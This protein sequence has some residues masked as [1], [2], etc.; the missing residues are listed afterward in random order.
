MKKLLVAIILGVAG[1]AMAELTAGE[2]SELQKLY[3]ANEG[4]TGKLWEIQNSGVQTFPFTGAKF[5]LN[6]A[7]FHLLS[8]ASGQIPE[9]DGLP[10][11]NPRE[12]DIQLAFGFIDEAIAGLSQNALFAEEVAILQ[13]FNRSLPYADAVSGIFALQDN[14]LPGGDPE[15]DQTQFGPHGHYSRALRQLWLVSLYINSSYYSSRDFALS[16]ELVDYRV[17]LGL[18]ADCVARIMGLSAH[19]ALLP[20]DSP[21]VNDPIRRPL[22]ELSI[23][24]F[25]VAVNFRK[26]T[27]SLATASLNLSKTGKAGPSIQTL[28]APIDHLAL[29]WR[30]L[31]HWIWLF[32]NISEVPVGG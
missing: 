3:Q 30:S 4:I 7:L 26:A 17:K 21:I 10:P 15:L 5:K 29:A 23:S 1:P 16:A 9:T 27:T 18:A 28:V 14:N 25:C 8:G 6:S 11:L 32:L 31:D 24:T 20:V 19:V 12:V 13:S 2:K 22:E